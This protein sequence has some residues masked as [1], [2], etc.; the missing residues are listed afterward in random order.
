MT[1]VDAPML[2]IVLE[3]SIESSVFRFLSNTALCGNPH[4]FN[5]R[6]LYEVRDEKF[7]S[8]SIEIFKE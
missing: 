3:L 8:Y 2:Y 6:R 4:K 5:V 7:L 1:V